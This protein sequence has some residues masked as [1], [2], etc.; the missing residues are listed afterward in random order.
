MKYFFLGVSFSA[1]F[2]VAVSYASDTNPS[3]VYTCEE[4][5][6]LAISNIADLNLI[7]EH[8]GKREN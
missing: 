2:A 5:L 6:D 8:L 7:I 1:L 3:Q 4:I